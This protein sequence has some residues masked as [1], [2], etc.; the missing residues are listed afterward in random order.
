VLSS[1][2]AVESQFELETM[3]FGGLGRLCALRGTG[4]MMLF[5][6]SAISVMTSVGVAALLGLSGCEQKYSIKPSPSIVIPS[7]QKTNA[8]HGSPSDDGTTT[9][10]EPGS[11]PAPVASPAPV[12]IVAPISTPSRGVEPTVNT[13]VTKEAFATGGKQIK[14]IDFLFVIDNSPSMSDKQKKLEQGFETFANTFFRRADLDICTMIITSDRRD[15]LVGKR[16]Y[17][18]ERSVP[19][20]KPAGSESWSESQMN[21]HINSV[22]E[23]FTNAADVGEHGDPTELLGKSLVSFLY[24]K[25]TWDKPSRGRTN[26]FR[27]DA[28]ANISFLTDENNYFFEGPDMDE[29]DNDL[30]YQTGI[31]IPGSKSGVVDTRKGIKNYL[32]E[33]FAELSP[34]SAHNYSVTT[35]LQVN[36]P[37]NV[38][39]G[40]SVNLS[41]LTKAVGR[42]SKQSNIAGNISDYTDVYNSIADAIVLRA[43]TFTLTRPVNEI[44]QAELV[45]QNGGRQLLQLKTHFTL[46]SANVVVLEP[47]AKGLI[48]DGD[49]L[50]I[51]YRYITN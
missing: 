12:V 18:R 40:I 42:E 31:K 3:N 4:Y 26:F 41:R 19:C 24:D 36:S 47:A 17:Q 23:E 8:D 44:L 22:I 46:Q 2:I 15:G 25:P 51:T 43:T 9:G 20:T 16:G 35:I 28:V 37:S 38:V 45:H 21:D 6:N 1:F 29:G 30:P 13:A 32:D 27:K 11:S 33:F 7:D 50:E 34:G 10:T 5:K 48:Q 39:P 49:Q 14:K